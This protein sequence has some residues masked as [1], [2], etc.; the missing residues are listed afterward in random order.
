MDISYRWRQPSRL[1][2]L[3]MRLVI[4]RPR[5]RPSERRVDVVF[6]SNASKVFT[7]MTKARCSKLRGAGETTI[8][9]SHIQ[10]SRDRDPTVTLQRHRVYRAFSACARPRPPVYSIPFLGVNTAPSRG[11]EANCWQSGRDRRC[12]T[13]SSMSWCRVAERERRCPSEDRKEAVA[14]RAHRRP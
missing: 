12:G 5:P 2:P 14:L 6:Q 7:W 9:R 4:G 10:E 13:R 1:Q 3:L 11:L 8:P